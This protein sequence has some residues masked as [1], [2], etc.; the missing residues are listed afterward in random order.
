MEYKNIDKEIYRLP[1]ISKT[2]KSTYWAWVL[3]ALGIVGGY[4]Y[5]TLTNIGDGLSSVLLGLLLLGLFSIVAII[6]FFLF[7]DCHVPF[8][9]PSKQKL[10]REYAF[11]SSSETEKLCNALNSHDYAALC[12]IK[13]GS[14]PQVI[15]VRYSDDSSHIVFSQVQEAIGNKRKPITDI[16]FDKIK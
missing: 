2:M 12:N 3:M 6:C 16:I 11:Y 8:Y 13:K 10:E 9:K 4:F 5:F 14:L 1:E 15:L 7:G